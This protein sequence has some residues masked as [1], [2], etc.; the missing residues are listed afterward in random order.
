MAGAAMEVVEAKAPEMG[1]EASVA[2]VVATA[3]IMEEVTAVAEVEL[4]MAEA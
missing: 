2:R 4:E 3:A 1:A